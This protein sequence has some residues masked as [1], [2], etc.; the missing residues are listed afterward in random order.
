MQPKRGAEEQGAARAALPGAEEEA[1]VAGG[2]AALRGGCGALSLGSSGRKVG[3]SAD[4][5]TP[6]LT[7]PRG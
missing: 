6:P 1:A 4:G 7:V 3:G 5:G 2:T